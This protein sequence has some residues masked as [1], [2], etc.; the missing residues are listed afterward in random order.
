MHPNFLLARSASNAPNCWSVAATKLFWRFPASKWKDEKKSPR[1]ISPTARTCNRENISA[2]VALRATVRSGILS[3][4]RCNKGRAVI[5][6]NQ[7]PS[8]RGAKRRGISLLPRFE[9]DGR[10]ALRLGCV[11]RHF[12]SEQFSF[13][14]SKHEITV[15]RHA[16]REHILET[17]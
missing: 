9:H 14:G 6:A 5:A 16:T 10:R 11:G 2:D 13:S 12:V 1:S 15:S 3:F 4:R 7:W 17:T 8:F